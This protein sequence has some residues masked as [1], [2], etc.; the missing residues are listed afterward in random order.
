[1]LPV[2]EDAT[3]LDAGIAPLLAAHPGQSGL[4]LV[5]RDLDAFAWRALSARQAGRSLD[6]QYY[7]WQDD[8][9]GRLL[10]RELLQA[11]DRGVRVRLLL[12]D[13]NASRF[14]RTWLALDS[15][16]QIEVRLFNPARAREGLLQRGFEMMLRAATLTRRMHNK[17]WIADGRLALVGGRN[18]GDAYFAAGGDAAFRDMDLLLLGPAVAETGAIF[19]SFWNS[20]AA[21]PVARLLRRARPGDLPA[22][23]AELASRAAEARAQ[24]YLERVAADSSLR[25]IYDGGIEPFLY[26]T[27]DA[28][29]L[30]D[31]PQ[32]VAGRGEDAWLIRFVQPLLDGARHRLDIVSPYF[33]PGEEGTRRLRTLNQNGVQ[34]TVL[35][36]SLAATDVMAVHGA[37][38]ESRPGLLEGGVNLFELRP[39]DSFT[40]TSLFGSSSASL[41][42]KAFIVDDGIGFVGSMNFDPRSV[43][44]NSE[45]G[46]FFRDAALAER[47]RAVLAEELAPGKSW[48]L[49]L[50]DGRV[51]WLD[52]SGGTTRL[53]EGEPE[54]GLWRRIAAWLI[55][56]LPI[57]SQL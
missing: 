32:K 1:M 51:V 52:A 4:A 48:Q 30:S 7:I 12:D 17:A 50:R 47:I 54:A 20:R 8:L 55:G 29:V 22:L 5:D 13:L 28:R 34:V 2:A 18:I 37:Y 35:T 25:D 42:T 40:R 19:D 43:S 16:P 44:L 9:T 39:Y 45:M 24:P 41:H 33:I 56:L 26:W 3:P 10:V 57:H 6:L 36:N 49:Q 27:P 53:L 11:A 14:D 15:H 21:K 38:A 46:V 31:P 23:R